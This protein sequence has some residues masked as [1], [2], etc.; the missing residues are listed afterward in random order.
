MHGLLLTGTWLCLDIIPKELAHA[1]LQPSKGLKMLTHVLFAY[2]HA[3]HE[4]A[5]STPLKA[6][7]FGAALQCNYSY[8]AQRH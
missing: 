3:R 1:G 8:I 6:E 2:M 5:L 7:E 4:L